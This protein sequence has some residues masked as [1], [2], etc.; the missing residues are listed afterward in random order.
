MSEPP[1]PKRVL[2]VA[3]RTAASPPLIDEV[4]ERASRGPCAFALLVPR[5]PE[6]ADPDGEE[7]KRT[8]ELAIPL[9]EEAA[10]ARVEAMAGDCDPYV[11]VCETLQAREFDEVIVS[12]LPER[13][14]RWLRRD[15]PH[16]VRQLGVPVTV[17]TAPQA[18]RPLWDD[19]TAT[20]LRRLAG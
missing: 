5:L 10:G 9:I 16:R 8:L 12:T 3:H 7:V 4:R 18:Q 1:T 13:V 20:A 2:I 14:S 15:L 11:A 19:E 6:A 17:V